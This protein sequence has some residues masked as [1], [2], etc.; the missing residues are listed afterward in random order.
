MTPKQLAL[1]EREVAAREKQ[2]QALEDQAT[3]L[4]TIASR[5]FVGA[6]DKDFGCNNI[7]EGVVAIACAISDLK[8][9]VQT[10]TE[11][12]AETPQDG[13]EQHRIG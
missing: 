7:A 13:E 9:A 3:A 5:L 6:I 10:L 1:Y 2:A 8:D 4:D 11:N 12:I